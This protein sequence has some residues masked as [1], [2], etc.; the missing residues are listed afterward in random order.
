MKLIFLLASACLGQ[1][2]SLISPSGQTTVAPGATVTLGVNVNSGGGYVAGEFVIAT[3]VDATTVSVAT[4]A[5]A[6]AASKSIQ[7]STISSSSGKIVRC[8]VLG[9]N[10]T[11]VN[12]NPI[13]DGQLAL[14]T[15]TFAATLTVPAELFTLS[16]TLGASATGT[17]ILLPVGVG[18]Y[19]FIAPNLCDVTG[20]GLVNGLDVQA[21][22]GWVLGLSAPPAG[23]KCDVDLSGSCDLIDVM[24][25]LVS[26]NGGVCTAK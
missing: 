9:L 2:V 7:C 17:K 3:P 18:S 25:I 15:A 5:Q 13:S 16:S 24:V 20:D 19:T 23:K 6:M 14:M 10:G 4:G 12:V 26:A 8:I 1:T 22:L 21:I 11:V